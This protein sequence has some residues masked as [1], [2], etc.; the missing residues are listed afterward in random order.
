MNLRQA[1]HNETLS[2]HLHIIGTWPDWVVTVTFYAA[3]HYVQGTLF[4]LVVRNGTYQTFNAFCA[5]GGPGHG[6]GRHG[7]MLSLVR[8]G[9][10]R[11]YIPYLRLLELSKTAR[12]HAYTPHRRSAQEARNLLAA[13]RRECA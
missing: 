2:D 13:V 12:Y 1:A 5:P 7:V 4:P 10:P 11:A 6:R 3:L 8:N 9:L